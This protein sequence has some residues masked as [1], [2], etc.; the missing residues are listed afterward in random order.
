MLTVTSPMPS[1]F[2]SAV[3]TIAGHFAGHRAVGRGERHVHRHVLV[4]RHIHL[5]DKAEFVNIHRD[6]RIVDGLE[7]GH[8]LGG[9]FSS[10]CRR[11]RGRRH[12]RLS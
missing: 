9:E 10:S 3:L 4:V 6:L 2:S 12:L 1:T 5:I 11:K 8:Q 7:R